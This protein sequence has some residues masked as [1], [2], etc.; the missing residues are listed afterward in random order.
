[1]TFQKGHKLGRGNKNSGRKPAYIETHKINAINV[2]WRKVND[3]VME[4]K[5]LSEFEEK[6]VSSILPKTIKT[7]TKITADIKV[8]KELTEEANTSINTYLDAEDNTTDTTGE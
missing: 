6:L 2:L 7:E 8:D 5:E 3:K 4:G 1:M